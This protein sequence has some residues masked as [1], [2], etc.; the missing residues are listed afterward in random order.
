[1][2]FLMI[3]VIIKNF[4]ITAYV[5]LNQV[6][7]R[8]EARHLLQFRNWSLGLIKILQTLHN[9]L[10]WIVALYWLLVF[11]RHLDILLCLASLLFSCSFI[12]VEIDV[13]KGGSLL[14]F[15]SHLC[16]FHCFCSIRLPNTN[17]FYLN[18]KSMQDK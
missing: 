11:C 5:F 1:M 16:L 3:A 15:L 18:V 13:E 17:L 8:A 12:S 6:I 2:F 7:E 9:E 10:L 4:V 14:F